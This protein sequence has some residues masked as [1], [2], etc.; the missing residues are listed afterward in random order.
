MGSKESCPR[1]GTDQVV[2]ELG[3]SDDC[4]YVQAEGQGGLG[5][6]ESWV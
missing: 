3:D 6:E 1:A 4:A 5:I 2:I